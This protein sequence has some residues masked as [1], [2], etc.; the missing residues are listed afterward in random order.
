MFLLILSLTSY[1][2]EPTVV[3]KKETEI[4]FEAVDIE[5]QLKKPQGSLISENHRAIFNPLIS[6]RE[7]WN[8][9]MLESLNHIQ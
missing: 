7:E 5:G 4:D 6:I 9:E 2:E 3:Y 1:A 8:N